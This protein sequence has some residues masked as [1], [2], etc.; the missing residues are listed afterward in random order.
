MET[1]VAVG[2]LCLIG[3]W[4]S[5]RAKSWGAER[6][7]ALAGLVAGADGSGT[8]N[9]MT[10]PSSTLVV[11]L[12]CLPAPCHGGGAPAG[13]IAWSRDHWP[14]H[15]LPMFGNPNRTHTNRLR[16]EIDGPQ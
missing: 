2:V 1:I 12:P 4:R 15:F 8:G 11:C 3:A 10:R 9:P 16:F 5:R 6:D 13:T 7:M 14:R